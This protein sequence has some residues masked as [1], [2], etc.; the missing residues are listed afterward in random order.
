[1]VTAT[2]TNVFVFQGKSGR[3]Y[4]INGYISDVVAAAVTFNANGAAAAGSLQYWR[5]PEAVRLF[6]ASFITGPTVSTGMVMTQDGAVI[7]G[8]SLL[9]GAQLNTLANR[10]PLNITF[11][12]GALIG[13]IQF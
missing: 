9:L 13:A 12:A 11:P 8:S 6:D 4:T 10:V 5:T 3:I 1:M 2:A 7:A